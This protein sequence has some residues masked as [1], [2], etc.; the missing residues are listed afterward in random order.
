M[1]LID[2]SI[3]ADHFRSGIAELGLVL[4]RGEAIQHPFVTGELAMGNPPDR[5]G[6]IAML[7]TLPSAA[8]APDR[9]L[10]D[11]IERYDLGGTGIGFVDAHLLASA[12]GHRA[13]L[14]T[15][16]KRLKAQAMRLS[17]DYDA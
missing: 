12:H 13:R 16:D 4:A 7:D 15:R 2:T 5:R 10:Y 8:A 14:W 3:W 11:F 9:D 6:L 1:I 17:L